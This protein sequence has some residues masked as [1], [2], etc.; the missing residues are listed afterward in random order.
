MS[1][2][3]GDRWIPLGLNLPPVRVSDIAIQSAQHSVVLATH[4]RGFWVLDD[5]QFLEQLSR[6]RVASDAPYLFAP[7]QTWLVTQYG[8]YHPGEGHNRRPGP[9]CSSTCR[10]ITTAARP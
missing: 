10:P 6:A 3:G 9:P 4:G 8:T 2:D 1:L 5:L 7:Q